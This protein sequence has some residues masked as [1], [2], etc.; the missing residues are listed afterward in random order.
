MATQASPFYE[1]Y[2]RSRCVGS[3]LTFTARLILRSVGR[4][5]MDTLDE[6]ISERR[7][8][9]QLAMKILSHFDRSIAEVLQEKVKSRMSFKVRFPP[10]LRHNT[11]SQFYILKNTNITTGTP[12]H[13]PLL[14]R[15]LDLPHQGRHL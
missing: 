4:T 6:L 11:T 12:R 7:I 14:R 1:L 2:R 10:S 15:G 3:Q 13:L 5:L 8:E 9:P